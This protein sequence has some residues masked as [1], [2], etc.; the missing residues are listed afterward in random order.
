MSIIENFDASRKAV[1]EQIEFRTSWISTDTV[2]KLSGMY[3]QEDQ[4]YQ[5]A[6]ELCMLGADPFEFVGEA[7]DKAYLYIRL[8]DHTDNHVP[9]DIEADIAKTC[10]ECEE[11]GV[12]IIKATFFKIFRNDIKYPLSISR[13]GYTFEQSQQ[14][15]KE[16]Y[17]LMGGEQVFLYAYMMLAEQLE[18]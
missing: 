6:K 11:L 2:E 3:W 18:H 17:K 16:Q 14:L 13:N 15:S 12:D 7:G 1:R 8:C 4:E 9:P 5:E 10:A